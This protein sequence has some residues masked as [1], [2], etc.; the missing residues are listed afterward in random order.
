MKDYLLVIL[1]VILLAFGFIL[2]KVYQRR[3]SDTTEGGIDFSIISAVFSIILLSHMFNRL[4]ENVFYS[5]FSSLLA[6]NISCISCVYSTLK[7]FN[8]SL[9]RSKS[10]H[11]SASSS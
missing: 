5:K 8:P 2:Q 11:V 4:I 3:T 9:N 7:S 1:S 6:I 10:E